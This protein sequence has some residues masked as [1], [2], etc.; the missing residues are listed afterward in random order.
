MS[1]ASAAVK[2]DRRF[3]PSVALASVGL[4]RTSFGVSQNYLTQVQVV[5]LH[6][7]QSFG[8]EIGLWEERSDV[9]R[10]LL[11]A[12]AK[13]QLTEGVTLSCSLLWWVEPM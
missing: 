2:P 8:R 12:S 3:L 4:T 13:R 6:G 5:I 9:D 10:W 11:E 7:K 1:F